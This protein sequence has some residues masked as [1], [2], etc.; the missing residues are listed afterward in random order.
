M[1]KRPV[2][3]PYEVVVRLTALGF[4]EVRQKGSY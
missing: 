2:L 1:A 4:A 3:K